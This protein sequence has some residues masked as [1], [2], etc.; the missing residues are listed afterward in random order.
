MFRPLAPLLA[1]LLA[2]PACTWFSS[3]ER[4]LVASEPL[5][6]R[7]FVDG[8]DTGRTTPASLQIG[9]L[10]GHDHVLELRK[11]GY[12][13]ARRIVVQYTEGYTS[14][15]IDGAYDPV[16]VPLPLFWTGGDFATPFG[17]RAAVIPGELCVRLERDDAPLLGF[18][19]LA[20]KAAQAKAGESTK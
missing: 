2:C 16:L 19:L 12:R 17:I 1:L 20:H 18:D 15:W 14:K 4:V 8:E 5:G 6:A 9:G 7:I 3:R 13:P 10:F 11:P